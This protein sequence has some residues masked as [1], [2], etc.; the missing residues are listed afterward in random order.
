MSAKEALKAEL[1]EVRGKLA[2]IEAAYKKRTQKLNDQERRLV[3][4]LEALGAKKSE[5]LPSGRKRRSP[6]DR[7]PM[8]VREQ[9]VLEI[10]RASAL[11]KF[12]SGD[13]ERE[14]EAYPINRASALTA[15][16]NLIDAGKLI[17]VDETPRGGPVAELAPTKFTPGNGEIVDGR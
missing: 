17:K 7:Q 4:A 3:A 8:E 14:G 9:Q 12:T 5:R 1:A 15:M 11:D 10:M 13:I 2:E 16:R 6:V